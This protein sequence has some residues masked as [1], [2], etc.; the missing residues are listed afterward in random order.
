MRPANIEILIKKLQVKPRAEMTQRNLD[1]ALAAQKKATGSAYSKLTIRRIIMKNPI[2]KLAAAALII[3]AVM[4]VL[5]QFGTSINGASAALAK[6]IENTNKRPWIR[7][8]ST[9]L[10]SGDSAQPSTMGGTWFNAYSKIMAYRA[11]TTVKYSDYANK[12]EYVYNSSNDDILRI[13]SLSRSWEETLGFQKNSDYLNV[14]YNLTSDSEANIELNTGEYQGKKVD[15]YTIF[16][17]NDVK[18]TISTR[19]IFVDPETNLIIV[20]FFNMTDLSGQL[21]RDIVLT[22]SYPD[23]GPKDI[24][25]LGVPRTAKVY[26][27]PILPQAN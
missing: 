26:R 7:I 23:E 12:I 21:L 3:I 9:D 14:S 19:D 15:I 13:Y 4:I 20:E 2:I 22:Y 18:K 6:V 8:V 27:Y 25:E 10:L 11:G 1:D 16:Y 17:E 5:N 24:Y